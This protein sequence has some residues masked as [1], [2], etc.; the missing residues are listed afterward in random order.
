MRAVG[1][2]RASSRRLGQA[3]LGRRRERDDGQSLVEFSLVLTPLLLVVLGI[4]QFGFVF[5][6]FVTL[7][8]A[9]REGARTGTVYIYDRAQSKSQNDTARADSIKTSLLAS[10]NLLGKTSPQFTT[11]S[12]WTSSNG[13]LTLTNG[14]MI[15]TYTVPSGITDNDPRVGEQVTV[16]ATYHEDLVIPLIALL[17]P[18]DSGGR[19]ALTVQTTMVIN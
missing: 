15:V 17:L 1:G 12:T 4:I 3:R 16:S 8:N 2:S 13:G 7:T 9:G 5:N 14:D 19:L 6:T 11:G 18:R 10:M